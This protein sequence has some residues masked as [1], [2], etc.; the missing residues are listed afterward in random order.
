MKKRLSL[1]IIFLLSSFFFYFFYNQKIISSNLWD[2]V[3]SKSTIIFEL[4]DPNT[5]LN[6]ILSEISESKLK[7]SVNDIINDYNNFNDFID[8]KIEKYLSENK[9][10][11]SFFN[12]SNKKLV[13]VYFSYKKNLDDD[14]ILKKLRDKGYDFNKRKLNGQIIFEAKN[15][16]VSHIFSFLDNKVVYSSNSIVIED[17]IRS[18]NNSELLFKNKNKSLFSQVKIKQDYG[19]LYINYND[20]QKIL[21]NVIPED[22]FRKSLKLLPEKSFYDIRN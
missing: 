17:V 22:L 14:F 11:I 7:N 12:L 16:E 20:I 1:F 6:K 18:I 8:G 9:I 4:E 10:I 15:D 3:P 13:P 5:Q 19:N 2:I 21:A